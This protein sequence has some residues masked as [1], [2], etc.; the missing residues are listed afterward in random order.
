MD[1]K[2]ETIVKLSKFL[3]NDYAIEVEKSI[4]K[5]TIEYTENNDNQYL[6]ESIYNTKLSELLSALTIASDKKYILIKNNEDA[7]N[8]AYFKPEILYPEKYERLLKKKEI[9]EYK[10][11]NVK[12]STAFKCSKCKKNKCQV[13]QKQIR[14]GDEPATT[15]VTC[16]ECGYVFSFN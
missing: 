13:T 11:N 7:C 5:F 14:A 16:L 10:K 3:N 2:E 6:L 12:S 15:F 9:E 8:F 1:N 4:N